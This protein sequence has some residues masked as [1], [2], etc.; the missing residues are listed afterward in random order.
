MAKPLS[1]KNRNIPKVSVGGM[2]GVAGSP[3]DSILMLPFVDQATGAAV[4][5]ATAL[6]DKAANVKPIFNRDPDEHEFFILNVGASISHLLTLCE[7]LRVT[8]ILLTHYR[9]TRPMTKAGVTRNFH[10]MFHV[11]GYLIR[12]QGVLDRALKLINAAFHLCNSDRNCTE[13]ILLKNTKVEHHTEVGTALK[14]L[15]KAVDRYR[16][17]RN[18]VVHAKHFMEQRL[19]YAEMYDIL[20][21]SRQLDEDPS[22]DDLFEESNE[23]VRELAAEKKRE[24]ETFN[25]ELAGHLKAFMETLAPIYTAEEAALRIR[26]GK[27]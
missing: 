18:E 17:E 23:L 8:P 4:K 26:L 24:F 25:V 13:H 14:V 27:P 20:A 9:T 22:A 19:R 21:R 1:T 7:H 3:F 10:V 12:V 2:G 16:A 15:K 6:G 5:I 11:E